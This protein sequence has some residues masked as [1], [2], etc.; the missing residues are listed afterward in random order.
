MYVIIIYIHTYIYINIYVCI[1]IYMQLHIYIYI[2]IYI[3]TYVSVYPV[4]MPVTIY[5]CLPAYT[6]SQPFL[7][8]NG[9][10]EYE[11]RARST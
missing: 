6:Y 10:L 1:Y 2:Y 3:Y 9:Q 4:F 5:C 11:V 8:E 7:A